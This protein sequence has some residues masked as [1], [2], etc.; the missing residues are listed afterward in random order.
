MSSQHYQIPASEFAAFDFGFDE[1]ASTEIQPLQSQNPNWSSHANGHLNA[2]YLGQQQSWRTHGLPEFSHASPSPPRTSSSNRLIHGLPGHVESPSMA[3]Q[4]RYDFSQVVDYGDQALFDTKELDSTYRGGN[5]FNFQLNTTSWD[6]ASH[7]DQV[8][9]HQTVDLH[10]SVPNYVQEF[11]STPYQQ[12]CQLL[13]QSPVSHHQYNY[14]SAEPSPAPLRPRTP[15]SNYP[16][17][18]LARTSN[19]TFAPFI[20]SPP[21][22]SPSR[23]TDNDLLALSGHFLPDIPNISSMNFSHGQSPSP[24]HIHAHALSIPKSRIRKSVS[25]A[26][27]TNRKVSAPK[28]PMPTPN[29]STYYRTPRQASSGQFLA[30]STSQGNLRGNGSGAGATRTMTKAK[31][32][33]NVRNNTN[34]SRSTSRSRRTSRTLK[35][36]GSKSNVGVSFVNFTPDDSQKLLSGVAPSGSSKTKARR[37]QEAREKKKRLE[38]AAYLAI[39]KAGGSVGDLRSVLH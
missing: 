12:Q 16:A 38:E 32:M 9:S 5:G 2:P 10:P 6:T 24:G 39:Q 26:A 28:Q 3:Y 23:Y 31:S 19:T 25:S 17:P 27:L 1:S 15:M 36:S 20:P 22:S 21:S 11:P 4:P 37:E 14:S 8:S 29:M 18:Q 33:S 7:T 13:D 35:A 34:S 30:S